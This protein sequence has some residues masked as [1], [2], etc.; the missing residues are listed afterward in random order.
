MRQEKAAGSVRSAPAAD[1]PYQDESL[2]PEGDARK[3]AELAARAQLRGYALRQV[4]S[5]YVLQRGI[6]S[7]HSSNLEALATVMARADVA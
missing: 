2:D 4:R 6:A 5:G 1:T 7:H 3:F